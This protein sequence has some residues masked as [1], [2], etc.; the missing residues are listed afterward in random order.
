M[1]SQMGELFCYSTISGAIQMSLR[2]EHPILR[3][4]L[5]NHYCAVH[6]NNNEIVV[7]LAFFK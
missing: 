6:Q 3:L 4:V 2:F 1:A 7:R 5:N